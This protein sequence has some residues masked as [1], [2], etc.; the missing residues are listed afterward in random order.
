MNYHTAVVPSSGW[1][2]IAGNFS[3]NAG[4]NGTPT[5]GTFKDIVGYLGN[6]VYAC[7]DRDISPA[8]DPENI[9]CQQF[10]RNPATYRIGDIQDIALNL[11]ELSVSGYDLQIDVAFDAGPGQLRLH[12]VANYAESATQTSGPGS[13]QQ[14]FAG[15]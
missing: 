3:T 7:F 2:S 13:P 14:E 4:G 12:G 6:P 10:Q 15:M 11:S 1:S 5:Y 9:Y 8:L